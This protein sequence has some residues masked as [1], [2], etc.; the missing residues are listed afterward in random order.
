M[1]APPARVVWAREAADN[2]K[3]L[4]SKHQDQLSE[5]IALLR[6]APKMYQVET[7]GKWRGLRRIPFR[8]HKVYY[9]Y[10]DVENAL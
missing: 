4:S 5:R 2:F 9:A 6:L 8:N 7:F 3:A 1:E 10:W